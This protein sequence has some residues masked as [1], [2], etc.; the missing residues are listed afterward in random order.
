MFILL[1]HHKALV[2]FALLTVLAGSIFIIAHTVSAQSATAPLPRIES[3]MQQNEWYPRIM[4]SFEWDIPTGVTAVAV[5]IAS[6]T[7]HEPMFV[8][9]PAISQYTVEEEDIEEGV[10]YLSV[11]FKDENGWGDIAYYKIQIDRTPPEGLFL[12]VVG[13]MEQPTLVFD[14]NDVLSGIAG[15]LVTVG[16][17]EPIY[18]TAQRAQSGHSLSGMTEGQY[19]IQVAA[20]DYAGNHYINSFPVFITDYAETAGDSGLIIG[21]FTNEEV[22]IIGL[23]F[24]TL[25]SL[26]L[27]LYSYRYNVKRSN[28]LRTEVYEVQE[29]MEKIFT[30]LRNEIHEQIRSIRSR[31]KISKKEQEVVEN[32]DK[33]FD[34]SN[35]LLEKEI[36]DVK[37]ILK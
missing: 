25:L 26:W 7:D 2:K 3:V 6:S 33:I 24:V 1:S 17:S 18:Y 35:A 34:V 28:K 23:T 37:N 15:Y 5:E 10:Q 32:L 16:Q 9:E 12:N 4:G 19:A 22:L 36:V 21:L 31:S 30:A 27:V 20:Y 13:G 11:Q 14:S 29:Q 8:Y